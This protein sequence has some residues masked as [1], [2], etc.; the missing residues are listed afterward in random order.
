MS[1]CA[2]CALNFITSCGI[3]MEYADNHFCSKLLA[4]RLPTGNGIFYKQAP[5]IEQFCFCWK[6][7]PQS[8]ELVRWRESIPYL[9]VVFQ[10]TCKASRL[11]LLVRC[12][13]GNIYIIYEAKFIV[14]IFTQREF[15]CLGQEH[16]YFITSYSEDP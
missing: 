5:N 14:L 1:E 9:S 7:F 4:L 12:H 15:R 6:F 16:A 2:F 8:W 13:L 10:R 3:S 11:L